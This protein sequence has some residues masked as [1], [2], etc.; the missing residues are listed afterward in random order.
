M[1]MK[2]SSYAADDYDYPT[3]QG[4]DDVTEN[5]GGVNSTKY[6]VALYKR[7]LSTG[8]VNRDNEITSGENKFC[9]LL[10]D[11]WLFT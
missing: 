1:Y 7:K 2:N 4:G 6:M 11:E 10:G 3:L 9:F 5:L 8:D